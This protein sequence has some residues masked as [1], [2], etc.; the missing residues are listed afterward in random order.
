MTDTEKFVELVAANPDLPIVG[1]VNG[2]I[3]HD[4]GMYWLGSFSG[5]GVELVGLV[6]ERYYDDVES[7]KEAYYDNHADELCEKFNYDPRCCTV[8]VERGLYTEQQFAENCLAEEALE[9]YLDEMVTKYMKKCIVVY[10]DELNMTEW[11]EA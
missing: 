2:D 3:C 7:F 10:V 6:G 8:N 4:Y 9:L 5:A 1:M 11:E